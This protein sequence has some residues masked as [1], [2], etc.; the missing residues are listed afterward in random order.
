MKIK[1]MTAALAMSISGCAVLAY[2]CIERSM[3]LMYAKQRSEASMRRLERLLEAEWHGINP[4]NKQGVYDMI[5]LWNEKM[6]ASSAPSDKR[7]SARSR[8][9]C[10]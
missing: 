8:F 3:A 2:L 6:P 4:A 10:E 1:T 9:A 5:T 7:R